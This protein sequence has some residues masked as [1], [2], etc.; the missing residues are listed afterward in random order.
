M[1]LGRPPQGLSAQA[2]ITQH[3]LEGFS[4]SLGKELRH[5]ATAN[6]LYVAEGA[7]QGLEG[8]LRFFL[9]PKSAF[10][11]GQVLHLGN[12]AI[13]VEDWTRPLAGRHALVTGAA[14]G[15]GAA[16]AETLARDGASVTLLD[17]PRRNRTSTPSPHAW[18]AVPWPW[19]SAQVMP[20]RNWSRRCPTA[21]ISSC[22][23]PASPA[24]RPSPT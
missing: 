2:S 21:W 4:R 13:Q 20:P 5:G 15:I 16:I 7:E 24:T 9:S 3:A 19:T 22:I 10:V 11:S 17:V 12:C 1:I 8:A 6:L 18:V 23:T 14:R